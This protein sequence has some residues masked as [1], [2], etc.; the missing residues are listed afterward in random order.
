[1]V[2]LLR[3]V[4]RARWLQCSRLRCTC[5]RCTHRPASNGKMHAQTQA[6]HKMRAGQAAAT[7]RGR[8]AAHAQNAA[9]VQTVCSNVGKRVWATSPEHS[10]HR[11]RQSIH[12]A[13]QAIAHTRY[14]ERGTHPGPGATTGYAGKCGAL[15]D[16]AVVK[17]WGAGARARAPTRVACAQRRVEGGARQRQENASKRGRQDVWQQRTSGATAGGICRIGYI[18]M[19]VWAGC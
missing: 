19:P 16:G 4:P 1:M 8:S 18:C 14:D 10:I 12:G 9:W 3:L 6:M 13:K 11:A 5:L 7:A 15:R 2:P 17:G